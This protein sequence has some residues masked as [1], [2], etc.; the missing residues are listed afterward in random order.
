MLKLNVVTKMQMGY[1]IVCLDGSATRTSIAN[2]EKIL[3][4]AAENFYV[5][6][7]IDLKNVKRM[8]YS[9]IKAINDLSKCFDKFCV[10]NINDE[11]RAMLNVF[12]T[13]NSF[14][15]FLSETEFETWI[16][17]KGLKSV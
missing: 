11:T 12:E 5:K 6:V 16:T 10:F 2:F 17:K 13:S 15:L 3:K 8:D 14:K 9:F 4:E 1:L 7:A